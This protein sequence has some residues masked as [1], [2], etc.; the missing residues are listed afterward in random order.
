VEGREETPLIV[1]L[2]EEKKIRASKVMNRALARKLMEDFTIDAGKAEVLTLAF[3]EKALLI[4]TDDKNT[5]RACKMLK[6]DFTTAIAIPMRAFE[7]KFVDKEEALTMLQ[8]LG[9][10]ARYKQTI[11]EDAKKQIKGR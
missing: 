11:I 8:K 2:I 6:I 3:Q 4:A 5:I 10:V 9:A 7:K 1:Q